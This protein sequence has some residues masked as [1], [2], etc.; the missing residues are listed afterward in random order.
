MMSASTIGA[1]CQY[2]ALWQ[3]K[4]LASLGHRGVHNKDKLFKWSANV[5]LYLYTERPK[6]MTVL[7]ERFN[8]A[9]ERSHSRSELIRPSAAEHY[10]LQCTV[11]PVAIRERT[12]RLAVCQKSVDTAIARAQLLAMSSTVHAKGFNWLDQASDAFHQRIHGIHV[13]N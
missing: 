12:L 6:D 8:A 10:W 13:S 9:Y 5:T 11:Y 7:I 2:S 4:P 1:D 3:I